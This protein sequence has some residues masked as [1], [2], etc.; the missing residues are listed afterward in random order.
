MDWDHWEPHYLRI[1]EQ[2]GYSVER[3]REAAAWLAGLLERQ[4]HD[5]KG[6]LAKLGQ[7]MTGR[8]VEVVGAALDPV[9]YL[10]AEGAVVLAADGAAAG[11]EDAGVAPHVVVTDLDGPRKALK[12]AVESGVMMV[13]HAHGD[14]QE[15]LEWAVEDLRP[16]LGTC[17]CQPVTGLF[18]FGGFTDGD[19]AVFLAASLGARQIRLT[20]FDFGEPGPYS[21]HRDPT[22]KQAKLAWAQRLMDVVREHHKVPVRQSHGV[23]DGAEA[24]LEPVPDS[25]S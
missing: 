24:R 9:D 18:N 2:F 4:G 12:R 7:L 20:G 19:R 22:V 15:R 23:H 21:H 17:Q 13:V 25:P 3:D 8:V 11:L 6:G 1:V 14:N 16:T 10:S 5:S